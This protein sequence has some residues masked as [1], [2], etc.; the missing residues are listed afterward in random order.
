M[1]RKRRGRVLAALALVAAA[2]VCARGW[3]AGY[4]DGIDSVDTEPSGNVGSST[5][6]FNTLGDEKVPTEE[7]FGTP[8]ETHGD[9]ERDELRPSRAEDVASSRTKTVTPTNNPVTPNPEPGIHGAPLRESDESEIGE[10]KDAS[11][12]TQHSKNIVHAVDEAGR[13]ARF[14]FPKNAALS[15]TF[16][17]IDVV[18]MLHNWHNHAVGAGLPNIVVIALDEKIVQW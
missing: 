1:G 11:K 7:K 13:A 3:Y 4:A 17:T 18:D 10:K 14:G 9:L 8:K 5:R 6:E 16:A 12:K 2:A 15:A